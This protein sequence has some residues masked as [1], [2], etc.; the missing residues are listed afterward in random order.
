MV[1]RTKL[2]VEPAG[3]AGLAPFVAGL[4]DLPRGADVVLIATGA[5]IDATLLATLLAP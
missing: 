1:E 5:N 2:V 4:L 3:A